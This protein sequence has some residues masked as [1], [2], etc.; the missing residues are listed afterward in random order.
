MITANGDYLFAHV[1]SSNPSGG[2]LPIAGDDLDFGLAN[3]LAHFPEFRGIHDESPN[4]VAEAI[5]VQVTLEGEF[6]ADAISER[7]IDRFVELLQHFQRQMRTDL[8]ALD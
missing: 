6:G 7:V 1:E 4:V 2:L 3:L 5:R 8:S